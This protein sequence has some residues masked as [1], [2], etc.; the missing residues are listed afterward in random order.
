MAS[1]VH[2]SLS[3]YVPRVGSFEGQASGS[4]LTLYSDG[5]ASGNG[6]DTEESESSGAAD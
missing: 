6:G 4:G 2:L 5:G 3:G 1:G